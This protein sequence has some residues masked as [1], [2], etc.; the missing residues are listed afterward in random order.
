VVGVEGEEVGQEVRVAGEAGGQGEPV[1]LE[2][3]ADVGAVE[4]EER[5]DWVEEELGGGVGR[6]EAAELGED[7][8]RGG[9]EADC[10]RVG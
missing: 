1:K 6:Q 8:E 7:E 10:G 5:G 2:A 9:Q 4:V 3:Y